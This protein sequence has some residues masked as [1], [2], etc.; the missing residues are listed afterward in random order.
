MS[1]SRCTCLE[2]LMQ[3]MALVDVTSK[4]LNACYRPSLGLANQT[5]LSTEASDIQQLQMTLCANIVQLLIQV[6]PVPDA[7]HSLIG[8]F[9]QVAASAGLR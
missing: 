8:A 9:K 1:R 5:D 4:V 2:L 3:A 6:T 7:N